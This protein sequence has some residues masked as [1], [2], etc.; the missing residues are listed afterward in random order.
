M[1]KKEG[2][3]FNNKLNNLL[4][5]KIDKIKI[6]EGSIRKIEVYN[7]IKRC[8]INKIIKFLNRKSFKYCENK[9]KFNNI[10]NIILNENEKYISRDKYKKNNFENNWNRINIIEED[11]LIDYNFYYFVDFVKVISHRNSNFLIKI[12]R[13]Q[14]KNKDFSKVEI[15]YW[16]KK[17]NYNLFY[18]D[19]VNKLKWISE[20]INRINKNIDFIGFGEDFSRK[21]NIKEKIVEIINWYDENKRKKIIN[22]L[23]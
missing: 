5:W 10:F 4:N 23:N 3:T 15:T 13:N 14:S 11:K 12:Y 7:Y 20:I 8:D 19:W 21:I 9:S 2:L 22:L 1:I 6:V 18:W 16:I 17:N